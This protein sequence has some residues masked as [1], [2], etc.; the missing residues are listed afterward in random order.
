[1]HALPDCALTEGQGGTVALADAWQKEWRR[2]VE[3]RLRDTEIG[4]S[5]TLGSFEDID[6]AKHKQKKK[7]QKKKKKKKKNNTKKTHN[8]TQQ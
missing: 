8:S 6:G 7:K 2:K 1:M 5:H 3:L 4:H